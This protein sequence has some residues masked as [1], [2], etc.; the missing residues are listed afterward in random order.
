MLL[1][2]ATLVEV[3]TMPVASGD[4]V[5]WQALAGW[6]DGRERAR[7]A[8]FVSP[9]SARLFVA[10]H[11]LARCALSKRA[12]GHPT[13]W[14]FD[15]EP[16]GKPQA[17][18]QPG[19]PAPKFSLA[20]AHAVGGQDT[21]CGIVGLGLVDHPECE[22]GFDLEPDDPSLQV[23]ELA[24]ALSPAES[25][26]LRALEPVRRSMA[27]VRLWTLKE[28]VAKARGHGLSAD[29]RGLAF[30]GAG[31][32][33]RLA[34]APEIAAGAWHLEHRWLIGSNSAAVAF[35]HAQGGTVQ[36]RWTE[37]SAQRLLQDLQS[38]GEPVPMVH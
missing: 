4:G 2:R 21:A 5:D 24:L 19:R 25:A 14:V 35:K 34:A 22:I 20:H 26:A 30:E 38:Q 7:L 28:A 1:E 11:A 16:G 32:H 12:G 13:G 6:L 29:L 23:A 8:A 18:G 9:Q 17:R 10:A 3:V 15:L 33:P 37:T 31:S 27:L 36:V